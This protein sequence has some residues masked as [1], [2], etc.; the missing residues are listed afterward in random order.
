M[1]VLIRK[2]DVDS[3]LET[4]KFPQDFVKDEATNIAIA[5]YFRELFWQIKLAEDSKVC[6]ARDPST[7]LPALQLI[8]A[9]FESND[10]EVF[11]FLIKV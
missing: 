8:T 2:T 5:T 11:E 1:K 3:L 6:K 9:L 7:V 10:F 4:M